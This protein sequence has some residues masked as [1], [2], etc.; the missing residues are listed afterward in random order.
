MATAENGRHFPVAGGLA[1]I[2]LG[3]SLDLL[4]PT[5]AHLLKGPLAVAA[6]LT[7]ICLILQRVC[8]GYVGY[9]A[10]TPQ[11]ALRHHQS[12]LQWYPPGTRPLEFLTQPPRTQLQSQFVVL[13]SET[14][15]LVVAKSIPGNKGC[16]YK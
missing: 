7:G 9:A 16:D 1:Q 13:G 8:S 6:T 14:C 4:W 10:S 15:L 12:R 3:F 5:W 2:W 11:P